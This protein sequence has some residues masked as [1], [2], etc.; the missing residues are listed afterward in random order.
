MSVGSSDSSQ[1]LVDISHTLDA[2]DRSLAELERG[3]SEFADF[4]GRVR[5]TLD[6]LVREGGGGRRPSEGSASMSSDIV[7]LDAS[8][9]GLH[10]SGSSV[11]VTLP[12]MLAGGGRQAPQQQRAA[13]VAGT[14]STSRSLLREIEEMSAP[15]L[16]RGS[17][18][19]PPAPAP[20]VTLL[21]RARA[22][23]EAAADR[24]VADV[25]SS[26]Y[27]EAAGRLAES[28]AAAARGKGRASP[29]RLVEAGVERL[30]PGHL[31]ISAIS[32]ADLDRSGAIEAGAPAPPRLPPAARTSDPTPA[33][34]SAQGSASQPSHARAA[35][36]EAP[37]LTGIDT[38]LGP[39]PSVSFAGTLRSG[40]AGR[41]QAA[42]LRRTARREREESRI[43]QDE[44]L[45][46]RTAARQAEEE[47]AAALRRAVDITASAKEEA[48][49]Q[50]CKSAAEVAS[51]VAAHELQLAR[52][53]LAVAKAE[54]SAAEHR[55]AAALSSREL[56]VIEGRVKEQRWAAAVQSAQLQAVVTAATR[57]AAS[58]GESAEASA[59]E[60]AH[61]DGELQALRTAL[62][63]VQVGTSSRG[64]PRAP[65]PP[66]PAPGAARPQ[67][68]I[69]PGQGAGPGGSGLGLPH[70]CVSRTGGGGEREGRVFTEKHAHEPTAAKTAAPAAGIPPSRLPRQGSGLWSARQGRNVPLGP[71]PAG[72]LSYLGPSPFVT[73]AVAAAQ[74]SIL[75]AVAAAAPD[76][77][78]AKLLGAGPR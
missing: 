72:R 57:A 12:P 34:R 60:L 18:T 32:Q 70:S 38:T 36:A 10:S 74:D 29:S 43:A 28:A 59:L 54:A 49:A 78:L 15:Q 39:Q 20:P 68:W 26:V 61:R 71:D 45:L 6:A 5:E 8:G 50:A 52:S 44:A 73:D 64:L 4:R 3:R 1:A 24:A 9:G 55:A 51:L 40:E 13:S 30:S 7:A 16:H 11:V 33:G 63:Q 75:R 69:V 2:L 22:S 58:L 21:T 48:A 41:A 37:V 76:T 77:A 47:G 35:R 42:A 19:L 53:A 27:G 46:A 23:D 31:H 66:S 56:I 67:A 65:G 25:L 14:G 62:E 17:P